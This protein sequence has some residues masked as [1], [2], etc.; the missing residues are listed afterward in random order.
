MRDEVVGTIGCLMTNLLIVNLTTP[1][2]TRSI[3]CGS[4]LGPVR[5]ALGTNGMSTGTFTGILGRCRGRCGG[6]PGTLITLNG[7][8]IVGGSC[9]GTLTMTSTIVT[10]CGAYNSTC[11]LGNSVCTVRSGNNRTT[12]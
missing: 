7:T 10:G 5:T 11:V 6:S 12:S 8:L 9:A 4:T 2:V 1:T 3:G